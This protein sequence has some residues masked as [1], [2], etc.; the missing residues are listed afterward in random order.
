MRMLDHIV[1]KR[2]EAHD[3]DEFEGLEVVL[4]G[5]ESLVRL[6][7]KLVRNDAKEVEE[8]PREQVSL[9]DEFEIGDQVLILVVRGGD[10]VEEHLDKEDE[11]QIEDDSCPRVV[12][13]ID[14]EQMHLR[15]PDS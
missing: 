15:G 8:K 2:I 3:P 7:E 1:G 12:V 11:V 4:G 14:N 5:E 6:E 13:L 10:E 9:D